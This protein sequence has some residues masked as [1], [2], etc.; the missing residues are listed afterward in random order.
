MTGGA[1]EKQISKNMFL[2]MRAFTSVRKLPSAF[3][4]SMDLLNGCAILTESLR[5]TLGIQK[6]IIISR[7]LLEKA[8]DEF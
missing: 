1:G 4:S 3:P 7:I 8:I 5:G 2:K 6:L